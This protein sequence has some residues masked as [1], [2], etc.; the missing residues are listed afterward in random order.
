MVNFKLLN[1]KKPFSD[2]QDIDIVFCRNVSIYF[3]Q[4]DRTVLFNKIA[5]VLTNEGLLILGGA[6]SLIGISSR[7]RLMKFNGSVFY[8]LAEKNHG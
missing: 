3:A 5:N 1:L 8:Q 2:F 6:E 4:K 7:F